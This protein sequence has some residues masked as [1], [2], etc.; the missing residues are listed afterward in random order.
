ML[1]TCD[2]GGYNALWFGSAAGLTGGAYVVSGV[3]LQ[4]S[5]NKCRIHVG[6]YDGDSRDDLLRTCDDQ[7]FN[8]LFMSNGTDFPGLG[9]V[10][11]GSE[12]ENAAGTC[13]LHVGNYDN[14]NGQDLLRTCDDDAYNALFKSLL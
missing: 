14:A 11:T 5:A 4:D 7:C 8:S 6:D 2:G 1:R 9:Y 12:L 10:L 13:S 3:E